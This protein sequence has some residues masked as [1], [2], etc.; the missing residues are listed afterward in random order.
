MRAPSLLSLGLELTTSRW[1]VVVGV[2]SWSSCEI[3]PLRL[4]RNRE[5][6]LSK[7]EALGRGGL[8]PGASRYLSSTFQALHPEPLHSSASQ[9]P[10]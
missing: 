1:Q 8:V 7:H 9:T 10:A 4:V 5:L 6:K 2:L 3:Q